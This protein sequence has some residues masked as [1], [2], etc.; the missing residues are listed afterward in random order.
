MSLFLNYNVIKGGEIMNIQKIP[1]QI[2]NG[3]LTLLKLSNIDTIALHHTA[4]DSAD[5][6]TVE[7]WHISN[8]WATIGYN[9][10]VTFDG[11]VYEG[12]GF[13]IGAG[14][15][16]HNS[17]VLSICFQGNYDRS[18]IMPDLQFN[19]GVEL[20]KFILDKVPFANIKAHRDFGG[21][22]CP[23]RFFPFDEMKKLVIR[24]EDKMIYNY[25]D[26]NMPEWAR[27]TIKKL[28][29]KGYLRGNEN[30]ELGLDD[31]ML[32]LLVINDRAGLY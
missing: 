11:T 6:K 25:I 20:I 15:L 14:V 4:H 8:G 28:V 9:Y 5:V 17:H 12:R 32:K 27:G 29:D 31:T 3:N 13:N 7:S 19:A 18:N 16:G 23:G 22:V 10:F 1:N 24:K 30:G 2:I 21:T 26:E